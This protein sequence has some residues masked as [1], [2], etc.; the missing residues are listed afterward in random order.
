MDLEKALFS[1]DKNLQEWFKIWF[2]AIL[3][4]AQHGTL[5]PVSSGD[6]FYLSGNTVVQSS[7]VCCVLVPRLISCYTVMR[8]R[9]TRLHSAMFQA[10]ELGIAFHLLD[11]VEVTDGIV[12][13]PV[14]DIG[15]SFIRSSQTSGTNDCHFHERRSCVHQGN[16]FKTRR[17]GSNQHSIPSCST[18]VRLPRHWAELK[19]L[20]QHRQ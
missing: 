16:K 17:S 11:T 5:I 19:S 9:Q 7:A 13:T 1:G 4:T 8:R 10:P 15:E 20:G 2:V 3:V 12:T 6:Q 18:T 14:T